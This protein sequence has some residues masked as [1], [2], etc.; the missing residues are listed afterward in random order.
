ML[1]VNKGNSVL[2]FT[3]TPH[4]VVN[5][6]WHDFTCKLKWVVPEKIHTPP[7]DG[8]LETLAG[9]GVEDSGNPGGRGG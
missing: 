5:P 4:D 2:R 1:Y 9:G 7:T 3:K 8:I 6:P